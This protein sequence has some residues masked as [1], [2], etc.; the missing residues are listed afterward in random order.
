MKK[1]L[2]IGC[3]PGTINNIGFYHKFKKN[4][5]IYGIDFLKKNIETIKQRFPEGIFT[6]GSAEDIPFPNNH[7]DYIVA[8]HIL[9]HVENLGKV[10]S[11]IYRVGKSKSFLS[12][13]V[14]DILLEN[15]LI[16][17]LPN[18]LEKGHHHQRL[19]AQKKLEKILKKNK[20]TILKSSKEKWPMFLITVF[21]A[22]C[23][24]LTKKISMEEQSGIFTIENKNYLYNKKFYGLFFY[25]YNIIS[26]L[27][28]YLPFF[29]AIIP[30]EIQILARKKNKIHD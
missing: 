13:A 9:E 29:N 25:I 2:D 3:G 8:H 17:T 16:R 5:D 22:Y 1:L 18:Y 4:Y 21:L 15:I 24:R 27:N 26:L 10:I 30:F 28:K 23:S 7:F 6:N 11:E 20:Y 14:P 19:L 12:V